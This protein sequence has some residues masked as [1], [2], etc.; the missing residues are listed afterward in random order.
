MN[1]NAAGI[2]VPTVATTAAL[3]TGLRVKCLLQFAQSVEL[4]LRSHSVL[5]KVDR[6]I[7]RNA[8]KGNGPL[9]STDMS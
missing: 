5:W 1:P 3:A 6:F 2:A 4:K 8:S 7:A 9:S